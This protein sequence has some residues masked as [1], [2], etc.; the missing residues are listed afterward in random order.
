LGFLLL[1]FAEKN[2][3][4]HGENAYEGEI[5]IQNGGDLGF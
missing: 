1:E 2:D 4:G 5:S 3:I